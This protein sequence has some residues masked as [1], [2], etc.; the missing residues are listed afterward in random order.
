MRM[1]FLRAATQS[2][3]FDSF[4]HASSRA[5]KCESLQE[6]A[7]ATADTLFDAFAE[8]MVLV[9]VFAVVPYHKLPRSDRSF[10]DAL[11]VSKGIAADI[12]P[13]TQVLSLLGTRGVDS[14]WSD[15]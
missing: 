4:R 13:D 14:A 7:Q 12:R 5:K 10:V 8:S 2:D 11:A 1:S 15:R 9:R 3:I 6:A